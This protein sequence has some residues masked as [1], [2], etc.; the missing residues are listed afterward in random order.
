MHRQSSE[1]MQVEGLN[2]AL[3]DLGSHISLLERDSCPR[4]QLAVATKF[5]SS[6]T[7]NTAVP[8]SSLIKLCI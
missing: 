1:R 3:N 7:S 6:A 2:G 8:Q 5:D 4:S